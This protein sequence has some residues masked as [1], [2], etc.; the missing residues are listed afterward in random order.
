[1]GDAIEPFRQGDLF[2]YSQKKSFVAIDTTKKS[3][4]CRTGA[5]V[6]TTRPREQLL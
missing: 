4:Q 6:T 1:M 3:P 2:T 5:S